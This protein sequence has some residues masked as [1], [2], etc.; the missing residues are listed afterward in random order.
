LKIG[1]LIMT[2]LALLAV[3]PTGRLPNYLPGEIPSDEAIDKEPTWTRR[4]HALLGLPLAG[5]W[6]TD[7]AIEMLEHTQEDGHDDL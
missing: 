3:I 7:S 4:P 2:G 1:L 5:G 6:S